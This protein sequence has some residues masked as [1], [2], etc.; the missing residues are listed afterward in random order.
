MAAVLSRPPP[1]VAQGQ[2]GS[3]QGRK[4]RG[5]LTSQILQSPS[6]RLLPHQAQSNSFVWREMAA[7]GPIVYTLGARPPKERQPIAPEPP[8]DSEGEEP[9]LMIQEPE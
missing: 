9:G 3:E 6:S 1:L 5:L 2:R 8:P 4:I 7:L